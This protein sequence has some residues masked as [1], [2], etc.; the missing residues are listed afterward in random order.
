MAMYYT[1]PIKRF[2]LRK[3]FFSKVKLRL[4]ILN[5]RLNKDEI[6]DMAH[7]YS[8]LGIQPKVIID[9]GAFIGFITHRFLK[10]FPNATVYSFEPNPKVYEKLEA[11]Y[12]GNPRVRTIPAGIGSSTGKMLF[13]INQRPVTNSFLQPN[14]HHTRNIAGEHRDAINVPITTIDDVMAKYVENHID[15]LKLDVEGFEIEAFK[16]IKDIHK[17]V[18]I[19]FAEVNLIGT[20]E[21]Q[22]LIEDVIAYMRGHH[23]HPINFYGI[24]EDQYHQTTITNVLF[25]SDDF[26]NQLKAKLGE[27]HFGYN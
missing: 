11:H 3:N 7:W 5:R 8:L 6:K 18:S 24:I 27:K 1:N 22:P 20:Y 25:I 21:N 10:Q 13:Q 19:V 17:K 14:A 16:G 4:N 2:L 26:K 15:I 23:F 9:G 12:K